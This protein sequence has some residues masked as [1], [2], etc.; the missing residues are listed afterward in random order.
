MNF[1]YMPGF[2]TVPSPPAPPVAAA[3]IVVTV[4]EPL[5]VTIPALPSLGQQALSKI[6][7][8]PLVAGE[9]VA[10]IA[11]IDCNYYMVIQNADGSAMARSSDGTDAHSYTIPADGWFGFSATPQAAGLP[12]TPRYKTGDTVTFLKAL[13]GVGPAVVEFYL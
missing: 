6:N 1:G 9:Y 8:V 13:S 2:G 3:P 5:P 12:S 7:R 11:P 10:I 4:T